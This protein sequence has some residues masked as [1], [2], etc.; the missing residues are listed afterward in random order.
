MTPFIC[1]LRGINL[2]GLRTVKMEILRALFEGAGSQNVRTY[3]Q[4]GN[5]VFNIAGAE[6]PVDFEANI[7]EKIEAAFG[8]SVPLL[9]ISV[10]D[11]EIRMAANP[12]RKEAK[13]P[14]FLH[15]TLFKDSLSESGI[16]A[17]EKKSLPAGNARLFPQC[18]Y[19]HCPDGYGRFKG[20]NDYWERVAG[21]PA[22][23]RN[24]KTVQKLVEMGKEPV[25]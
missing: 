6:L 2:G 18:A 11:L 16:A 23:T 15:L 12:F 8:F 20:G 25:K 4:S 3:I 9:F 19:L 1:L 24:W 5:V 7:L 10:A 14:A 22:T 13:D 21:T 17:Y